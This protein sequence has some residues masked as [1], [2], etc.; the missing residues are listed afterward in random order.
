MRGVPDTLFDRLK[1][2]G[3]QHVLRY[4]DELDEIQQ[5]AIAEQL[6]GFDFD[7]LRRLHR[8]VTASIDWEGLAARAEPP[9]A[10]RLNQVS[11][12]ESPETARNAGQRLLER[13]KVAAVLVAGGQ[14]TR[15]GFPHPKGMYRIGPVSNRSL[16]QMHVD[17]LLAVAER[18]GIKIPL[19]LMTSPAT[20]D[21]TVD[22]FDAHGRFGLLPDDFHI[23]CQGTMPTIDQ[24]GRLLLESKHRICVNPDGHGGMLAALN[25]SGCLAHAAEREIEQLFYFQVD[26][27]LV[28]VCDPVLLGYHAL[29]KSDMSTLV[30]SKKSPLDKVGNVVSI[31]CRLQV[32]EYSDLSNMAAQKQDAEGGLLLWAGN[33][34]V[35]AFRRDFLERAASSQD[36]LPFHRAHKAVRHLDETGASVLPTAPNATKFERFI[37]DL[38]PFAANA[39]AV[40]TSEKEGFAPLKNASGSTTDT[41]E[42]CRAAIVARA[43]RWLNCTSAQ[44]EDGLDVEIHPRFALDA[45]Q[46]RQKI[47]PG[48]QV[49]ESIFLQST[50][51]VNF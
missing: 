21:E 1:A 35:H 14:G 19:Y 22:Y 36:A 38:M 15:L 5:R 43:R 28:S 6:A 3:Q 4:W 9:A 29:A 13:G 49:D 37:F 32:I 23:F 7:L 31:D 50:P 48:V 27:P 40:E 42:A 26:N 18:Y 2:F 25:Q 17:Q 45:D 33:I 20:H 24:D 34:A 11:D 10:F 12:H 44:I 47:Q 30:V 51:I 16:F 41:P 39:I 8:D 46:L